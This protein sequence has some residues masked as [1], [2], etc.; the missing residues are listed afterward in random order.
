MT[1]PEKPF[2]APWHGQ[3]FALAVALNETG[4]FEWSEWAEMFGAELAKS[5]A[6]LDGSDDYYRAW[7]TTL[8]RLL[9][10]KGTLAPDALALMKSLW[11]DAFLT[12][13]HGQ[14][15]HPKRPP[16]P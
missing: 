8:E 15:V 7:V 11:T 16:K 4:H 2:E 14:P 3:A 10:S 1:T 6:E 12:T 9:V 5:D 13:P